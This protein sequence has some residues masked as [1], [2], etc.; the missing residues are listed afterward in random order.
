MEEPRHVTGL[1]PDHVPY[2]WV[3]DGKGVYVRSTRRDDI[4]PRKIFTLGLATSRKQL[5]SIG[6][7]RVYGITPPWFSTDGQAYAY[8]YRQTLS[9][10]YVAGGI[11]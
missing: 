2:Q 11:K 4:L 5:W 8:G 6:L 7:G 10:L 9:D 3:G 1:E